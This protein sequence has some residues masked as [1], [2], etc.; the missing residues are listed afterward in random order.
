MG[1]NYPPAPPRKLR[2]PLHASEQSWAK[3]WHILLGTS[4]SGP[5]C[6]GHAGIGIPARSILDR[7]DERA[8]LV[9]QRPEPVPD[10][11]GEGSRRAVA[12]LLAVERVDGCDAACGGD[13]HQLVG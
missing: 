5:K 4:S 13:R 7:F 8:R 6:A 1:T 3:W 10:R 9:H 12:D 11:D 2:A